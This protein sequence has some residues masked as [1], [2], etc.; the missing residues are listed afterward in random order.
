[1]ER[2]TP[3]FSIIGASVSAGIIERDPGLICDLV[4]DAYRAF[5]A[6]RANNPASQFLT[7]SGDE[8]FAANRI[9][10]LPA[11][12]QREVPMAGIKWV[13]SFPGNA[14][15]GLP[16]ASAVLI[17]NDVETG[18]PFACM[19]GALISAARTAASAIV[20]AEVLYGGDRAVASVGFIGNGVIARAIF[21]LFASLNWEF[22]EVH[23]YDQVPEKSLAFAS[24]IGH[25]YR[26]TVRV[27]GRIEGLLGMADLI[28]LATTA[29]QPH[30]VDRE[31]LARNPRIL[32]ISLRDLAPELILLS[33][34]IV[35]D[36][37]HCLRAHTSLHLA[38][39]LAHTRAFVSAN[40]YDCLGDVRPSSWQA[41]R[42]RPAIF[43]PFGMG[44][45]DV[46]VGMHVY[47]VAAKE[48]RLMPVEG[49]F[50]P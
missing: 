17:L 25:R 48:G 36:T 22:D 7:F 26:R 40:I 47:Q 5:G 20:G 6:G 2:R 35:D 45:L 18:F 12:V 14:A 8:P 43:S 13:S 39:Q 44:I 32:N 34:N 31:F 3:R 10:A 41:D 16:R 4:K 29:P 50:S 28:V 21:N 37:E 11:F 15:L 9:I 24:E 46:A 1:M 38:E 19:E 23:L 49:F 27:H 33:D 42:G 30:I